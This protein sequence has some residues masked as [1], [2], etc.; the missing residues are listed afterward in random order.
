MDT[1]PLSPQP[2]QE[3]AVRRTTL[4][5]RLLGFLLCHYVYNAGFLLL[6]VA[7]V[8]HYARSGGSLAPSAPSGDP[9]PSGVP[10]LILLVWVLSM[11]VYLLL[12]VLKARLSRWTVPTR[13][14]A[15][16]TLAWSCG[17]AVALALLVMGIAASGGWFVL[18]CALFAA[19]SC[20]FALYLTLFI[21]HWADLMLPFFLLA[22]ALAVVLAVA[23]PPAL[24]ALGSFLQAKVH[25]ACISEKSI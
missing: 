3:P 18:F 16:L 11:A 15:A 12:G 4:K 7:A 23:L 2:P 8:D 10:P 20:F 1:V 5:D 9:A 6:C 14:E 17:E 22:V 24:F 25:R 21:A 19:P 13:R